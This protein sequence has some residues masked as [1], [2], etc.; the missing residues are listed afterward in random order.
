MSGDKLHPLD[1]TAD[2][3]RADAARIKALERP[4]RWEV[5]VLD[6]G[7]RRLIFWTQDNREVAWLNLTQAQAGELAAALLKDAP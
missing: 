2:R 4:A 3:L 7:L 5:R 1:D 6:D